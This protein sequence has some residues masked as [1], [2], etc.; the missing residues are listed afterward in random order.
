MPQKRVQQGTMYRGT[1]DRPSRRREGR[2]CPKKYV[3]FLTTLESSIPNRQSSIVN[4]KSSI[5]NRQSQIVNQKIVIRNSHFI[6]KFDL[7][8]FS[9]LN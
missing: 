2:I 4:P 9:V 5:V 8:M 3:Y 7:L 6:P 1:R